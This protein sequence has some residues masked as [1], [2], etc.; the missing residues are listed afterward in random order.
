MVLGW[1]ATGLEKLT[2][3]QPE[4]LSPVKFAW[5]SS[6]PLLVQRLPTWVPVLV[7]AL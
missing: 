2:C 5:A 4:E 1:I 3:C 7:E 6:V